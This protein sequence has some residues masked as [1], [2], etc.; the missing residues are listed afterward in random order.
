MN[1]I[2]ALLVNFSDLL[3]FEIVTF[4][5]AWPFLA[6][7]GRQVTFNFSLNS[8]PATVK[9]LTKSPTLLGFFSLRKTS[10]QRRYFVISLRPQKYEL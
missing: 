7:G 3:S 4:T 1:S 5:G 8:R 9:N 6:L 2:L 10:N